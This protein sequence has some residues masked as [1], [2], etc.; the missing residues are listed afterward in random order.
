M[1][2]SLTAACLE[3]A[4]VKVRLRHAHL[5]PPSFQAY[6]ITNVM[7][8][9]WGLLGPNCSFKASSSSLETLNL[10]TPTFGVYFEYLT[11]FISPVCL[12]KLKM[13][14]S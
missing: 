8:T 14:K 4:A 7:E 1:M 13:N 9:I 12:F 10:I 2:F 3:L 5:R 6:S 11:V